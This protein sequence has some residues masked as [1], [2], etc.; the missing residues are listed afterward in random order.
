MP[1]LPTSPAL[2]Q[3]EEAFLRF[4]QTV[5]RDDSRTFGETKLED[6]WDAVR[7]VEKRLAANRALC[8]LKRLQ[9][10]LY[11][12]E[13]YS[14]C[15]DVL[16]NATP[17]LP[18]IWAP[19]KLFVI[20]A[21]DYCA[22]FE[23][24]IEANGEI[25]KA[26]PKFDR[27]SSALQDHKDFQQCLALVYEDILEFH[28][29]AYKFFRAKAWQKFF[30]SS[31]NGFNPRFKAVIANIQRNADMVD[32][33]ANSFSIVTI[34]ELRQ[35]SLEE[36]RRSEQARKDAQFQ[37]V[38][39]WLDVKDYAHEDDYDRLRDQCYSGTCDWMFDHPKVSAWLSPQ[40]QQA[41]LWF[42]GKPGS[43]KSVLCAQL[44][45]NTR[46][47]ASEAVTYNIFS[48]RSPESSTCSRMLRSI[49]AQL[50]K[51]SPELAEYVMY[52][53]IRNGHEP[54]VSNC[55]VLL[56]SLSTH[57]GV[58]R[59]IIDGLDECELTEIKSILAA[60]QSLVRGSST[61]GTFKIAIF[62][63]DLP[64]I[65]KALKKPATLCLGEE[66]QAIDSAI[67]NFVSHE[68]ASVRQSLDDLEAPADA[69]DDLEKQLIQK[70][71]GMI[72]WVR[73]IVSSI[74]NVHSVY[75]LR[76]VVESL[77]K[78][79]EEIYARI[80]AHLRINL[81]SNDFLKAM[82]LLGCVAFAMRPMKTHELADSVAL[83]LPPHRLDGQ[84]KLSETVFGIC[85][86]LVEVMP[87]RTVFRP[88]HCQRV[89]SFG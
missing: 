28:R 67:Q 30:M 64:A 70:A 7:D 14:K 55:K 87:D 66:R 72:L 82:K 78:G 81:P 50:V 83:I 80:V 34:Q 5:S 1:S 4:Q 69:L 32:K 17:F 68:L 21:S 58:V 62:S 47:S 12:L 31:W 42:N 2:Q 85:K 38:L 20:I 56:Q 65:Q 29:R 37:T 60:L 11:F 26:L 19:I 45:R 48:F 9:P 36:S 8:N 44:I 23:R 59:I 40:S 27:L 18:W 35:K 6:V 22:A 71:D 89:P 41:L 3:I 39:H 24:L 46:Q 33:E 86:P 79:L 51:H 53:H 74:E 75:E 43:G 61:L 16:C 77:P 73:L 52:N 57:L 25:G 88:L 63:R 84:T 13:H 10:L 49:V 76:R 15:V 54:S